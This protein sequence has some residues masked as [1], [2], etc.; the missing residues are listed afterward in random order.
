MF[1]FTCNICNHKVSYNNDKFENFVRYHIMKE[2]HLNGKQYYDLTIK[3]EGDDICVIC[4]KTTKFI[5]SKHGYRKT[6]CISCTFKTEECSKLRAE[7]LANIDQSVATEK[8]HKTNLV[9]YGDNYKKDLCKKG[10]ETFKRRYNVN[11]NFERLE[12]KEIYKEKYLGNIKEINAKRKISYTGNKEKL[13]IALEKRINT[14]METHGCSSTSQL[15]ESKEKIKRTNIKNGKWLDLELC[16]DKWII[17]KTKVGTL[18]RQNCKILFETWD[19]LDYYTKEKLISNEEYLELYPDKHSST[20]KLQPTI[21]HKI[22]TFY[23]FKN[24]IP[25]EIIADV[26][27]LC[28]CGRRN[29]S[30]K[31]YKTEIEYVSNI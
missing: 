25:I 12:V 5:G 2:H 31:N 9:K 6:C 24:D 15:E 17:Y 26:S 30:S 4:S 10:Y 13:K 1:D 16:E 29:N 22:S 18:S 20:N 27:N 14:M 23:G 7:S 11:S 21:D 28:I 3:K 8:R 19:G